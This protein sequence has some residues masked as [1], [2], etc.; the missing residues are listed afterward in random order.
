[1]PLIRFLSHADWLSRRRVI[2]YGVMYLLAEIVVLVYPT[3]RQWWQSG[4]IP[5]LGPTD[6]L[7]FYASGYLADGA[8]APQIYDIA[9]NL[10]TQAAL[11]GEQQ[12]QPWEYFFLYPPVFIL[13]CTAFPLLSYTAAYFVWNAAT[14]TF[15]VSTV[16]T[17]T[18][19]WGMT[20][21]L[22]SFPMIFLT[23]LI[24]QNALL[25]AALFGA[26]TCLLETSP[27]A[28]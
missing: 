25:T 3:L 27:I 2:A 4:A 23:M 9:T 26:G 20:L 16:R 13:V 10:K 21:A 18:R 5:S 22:L 15:L 8:A 12:N 17:I 6:F 1:M 14:F 19:D 28:A 24:G 11:L 7:A